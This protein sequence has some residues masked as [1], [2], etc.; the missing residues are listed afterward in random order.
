MMGIKE[1]VGDDPLT[2]HASARAAGIP[3]RLT[4]AARRSAIEEELAA[5]GFEP[6]SNLIREAR[7]TTWHDNPAFRRAQIAQVQLNFPL[8]FL[9]TLHLSKLSEAQGWDRILMSGRGCYLWHGLYH[10]MRPL[11]P[12]APTA[13]Y[14]HTSRVARAHPSI[15]YLAYFAEQ[16]QGQRN[17]VVDLC[18]TGWSASRLVERAPEPFADIFLLHKMEMPDLVQQYESFGRW[19]SPDRCS[20]RGGRWVEGS[21]K[22]RPLSG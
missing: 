22:A 1:H 14:F 13:A 7:L 16:R 8:L 4:L 20:L 12:G 9:A 11:L 15:S 6:L 19:T 2:D 21:S 17:V 18:G 10:G 3:A 5:A